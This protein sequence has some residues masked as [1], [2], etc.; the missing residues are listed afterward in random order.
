MWVQNYV[1]STFH[2]YYYLKEYYFKVELF[3]ILFVGTNQTPRKIIIRDM[4]KLVN[5]YNQ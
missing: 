3:H 1:R 2:S 4:S 5:Y